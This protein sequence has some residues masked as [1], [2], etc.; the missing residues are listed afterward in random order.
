M[1]KVLLIYLGHLRPDGPLT[2]LESGLTKHES[3]RLRETSVR[4]PLGCVS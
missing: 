3:R 2:G 1:I 4:F